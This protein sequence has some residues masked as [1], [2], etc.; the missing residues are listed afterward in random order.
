MADFYKRGRTLALAKL[1]F[2]SSI[3]PEDLPEFLAVSKRRQLQKLYE[4]N[5]ATG[6]PAGG[7]IETPN[8]PTTF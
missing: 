7:L 3:D 5:A 8:Y 6:L 4:A 1:G 2:L